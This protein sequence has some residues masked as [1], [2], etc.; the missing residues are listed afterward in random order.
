M[1]FGGFRRS[2]RRDCSPLVT[3]RPRTKTMGHDRHVAAAINVVCVFDIW[4]PLHLRERTLSAA[5]TRSPT[6]NGGCLQL[7]R[8]GHVQRTT[9]SLVLGSFLCIAT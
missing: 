5:A 8:L 6:N 2:S 1:L 3:D 7:G 9:P 4:Q